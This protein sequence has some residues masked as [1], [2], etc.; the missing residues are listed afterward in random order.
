[1]SRLL[2]Q[3]VPGIADSNV[4]ADEFQC[5]LSIG[6]ECQFVVILIPVHEPLLG[7]LVQQGLEVAGVA[8]RMALG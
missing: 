8:H 3:G 2:F 4:H 6:D 7:P 5:A 1:M